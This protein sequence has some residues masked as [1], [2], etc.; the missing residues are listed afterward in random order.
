MRKRYILQK[1]TPELKA[2]AVFEWNAFQLVYMS[3]DED[4]LDTFY[5]AKYVE[6]NYEWF[7]PEDE[8][9]TWVLVSERPPHADGWYLVTPNSRNHQDVWM[10]RK[11][12]HWWS[13]GDD[14]FNEPIAWM[15]L[16]KPYN[17]IP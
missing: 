7:L 4:G 2:G 8:F 16:P 15:P 1:D 11:S 12:D 5:N 10:F 13:D 17:P 6:N 14:G 9:G 3:H